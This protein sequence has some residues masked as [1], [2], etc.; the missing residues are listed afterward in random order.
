MW[1]FDESK[2]SPD[3][4]TRTTRPEPPPGGS[5][6]S[7]ARSV[8]SGKG[9]GAQRG[10]SC[11]IQMCNSSSE[12]TTKGLFCPSAPEPDTGKG[13]SQP[14]GAQCEVKGDGMTTAT[15]PAPSLGPPELERAP[16]GWEAQSPRSRPCTLAPHPGTT[17]VPHRGR[18]EVREAQRPWPP[19]PCTEWSPR[20]P[21]VSPGVSRGSTW[22]PQQQPRGSPRQR[23]LL[24]L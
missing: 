14:I 7:P 4:A 13:H 2:A 24:L 5:A 21:R 23:L 8:G 6:A 19:L 3:L 18:W 10:C 16:L 22:D 15:T 11:Q 9:S 1:P 12:S 17:A 20:G